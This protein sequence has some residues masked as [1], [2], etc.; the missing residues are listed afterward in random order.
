MSFQPPPLPPS[1][2]WHKVHVHNVIL[3]VIIEKKTKCIQFLI[4]MTFT[5][6]AYKESIIEN[7][8]KNIDLLI[9]A[10]QGDG[11]LNIIYWIQA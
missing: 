1:V 11:G 7:H 4:E 10:N 2:I 9:Q 6:K 3:M 8:K 5:I